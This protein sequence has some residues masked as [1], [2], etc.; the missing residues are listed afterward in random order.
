M[1]KI[2]PVALMFLLG[3]FGGVAIAATTQPA[4]TTYVGSKNSNVYHLPTCADAL[5]IKA[6]NLRTFDSKEAATKAG[7]RAC[8]VCKP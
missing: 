7:Y 4:K 6:A 8:L 3:A 1:R 5:K 2:F